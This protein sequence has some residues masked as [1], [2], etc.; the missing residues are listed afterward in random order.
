MIKIIVAGIG[1]VGGYFGGLL[2]RRYAEDETVKITFIA[3]GSH[4]EHICTYGLKVVKGAATFTANPDFATADAR[5]AGPADYILLCTKTYDLEA[6]VRQLAPCIT[7]DTV[8][9]PLQNGVEAPDKIRSLFPQSKTAEACTYIV[10]HVKETGVIEN[11]GTTE[12]LF[13]GLQGVEDQRL[14]VLEQLLCSAGI[15][16]RLCTDIHRV[17]WEK[18]L[19][20]SPAATATS[21]FDCSTGVLLQL[22]AETI[23]QLIKEAI[24]VAN[25]N[26]IPVDA[27]VFDTTMRQLRSLP[28]DTTTS[29]QR[30]FRSGAPKTEL[31][32][33]TGYMIKL[34]KKCG[35]PTPVYDKLYEELK[36][37]I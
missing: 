1:G 27:V 31:E 13:F 22:H 4:L 16:A 33:L 11:T 23:A 21:Y 5:T 29:M 3:R 30:D 6:L 14:T 17:V 2:A 18:F 25:A 20:L 37:R 8:I 15:P 12:L 34:G 28:Y 9:V 32:A 36:H 24:G 35:V 19:F 10:S 7:P 26:G